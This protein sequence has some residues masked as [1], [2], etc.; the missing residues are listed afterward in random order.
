MLRKCKHLG[1]QPGLP[2][3]WIGIC[4]FICLLSLSGCATR[5]PYEGDLASLKQAMFPKVKPQ[6]I[7]LMDPVNNTSVTK[8]LY[9]QIT[10][11]YVPSTNKERGG[12]Y[13]YIL[14]PIQETDDLLVYSIN[15]DSS[16]LYWREGQVSIRVTGQE[17]VI[18]GGNETVLD[19]IRYSIEHRPS[20]QERL[21]S[22]V[23]P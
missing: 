9:P 20:T 5:I 6:Q 13:P 7:A 10:V 15:T 19:F 2:R 16:G 17:A 8:E 18:H 3:A 11:E 14:L 21:T 23:K 12:L 1:F 22:P 4:T